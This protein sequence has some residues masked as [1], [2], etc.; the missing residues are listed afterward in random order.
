MKIE[1][2]RAFPKRNGKPVTRPAD[3]ALS[4]IKKI[5]RKMKKK[6]QGAFWMWVLTK[7]GVKC[8]VIKCSE[9]A[10]RFSVF[11]ANHAKA[12]HKLAKQTVITS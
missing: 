7:V 6:D 3:D 1:A 9:R 5:W 10:T 8:D 11:C 2:K 4:Q 12:I